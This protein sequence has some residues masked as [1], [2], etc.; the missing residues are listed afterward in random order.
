[1]PSIRPMIVLFCLMGSSVSY[2]DLTYDV[3]LDAA[4]LIGDP[5]GPFSLAFQIT[6]GSFLGDGNN[7][8]TVSNLNLGSG[9]LGGVALAVGGVTGDLGSS[10]ALTDSSFL[11]F[12]IQQFTP[13]DVLRFT[14]DATTNLDAGGGVDQF[15]FSILDSSGQQI[16][17][18][19]GLLSP[20]FDVFTAINFDSSSS[21]S[22][23]TFASDP[24][25][26]PAGGGPA[27]VI[28]APEVTSA[29]PEPRSGSLLIAAIACIVVTKARYL[30]CRHSK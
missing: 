26:T 15:T 22:I 18:G 29:V 24:T 16:P 9:S 25:R 17:T 23:Q 14:L 30:Y 21:P 19:G 20:F 2:A 1:M 13:G 3:S 10:M 6:D 11:S 28:G 8:V 12:A 5:A 27:I 7:T 4:P